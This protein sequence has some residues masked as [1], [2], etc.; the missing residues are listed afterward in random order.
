M[1]MII[2]PYIFGG[3]TPA[4]YLDQLS[5]SPRSA[6]SLKKLISTAT[7][8]IRVRR[9]SDD[10]EQ[11]IGF[12]G[13]ALDTT[14]LASFVGG[15]SAYIVTTYDQTGNGEHCVCSS[16]AKQPRIVNAGSYDAI[17][18]F[19]GSDDSM[20]ITS[21][22]NTASQCGLYMTVKQNTGSP[23]VIF[24]TSVNYGANDGAL[25]FYVDTS[26]YAAGMNDGP[27]GATI[28]ANSFALGISTPQIVSLLYDRSLTGTAQIKAW[29]AGSPISG[30]AIASYNQ[31]GNFA[32]FDAHIGSRADG[33]LFADMDL[34]SIVFYDSDTSSIRSAIEGFL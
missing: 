19:D 16:N 22:S 24:E 34:E 20:V 23:K 1:G 2:N 31:T 4:A 8:A 28:Q 33:S 6:C 9:S 14:S 15:N 26:D 25:I 11:D 21:L 10:A 13:D 30:S 7:L 12:S 3:T 27:N 32:T 17:M 29:V 5:P 18:K